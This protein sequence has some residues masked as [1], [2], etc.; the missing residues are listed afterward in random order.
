MNSG[1]TWAKVRSSSGQISVHYYNASPGNELL[2]TYIYG[3]NIIG[4]VSTLPPNII[5]AIKVCWIS[6]FLKQD[7]NYF[8]FFITKLINSISNILLSNK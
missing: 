3:G 1:Q 2:P 7:L 5:K 4:K 8:C 6:V